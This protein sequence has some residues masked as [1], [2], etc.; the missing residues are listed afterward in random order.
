MNRYKRVY[1][2][3][4]LSDETGDKLLTRNI[5]TEE[6]MRQMLDSCAFP[7]EP[8]DSASPSQQGLVKI[9]SND[10]AI[11]NRNNPGLQSGNIHA[12]LIQQAPGT[13]V[14][15]GGYKESNPSAGV[16]PVPVIGNGIKVTGVIHNEG[17]IKR[18]GYQVEFDGG[19]LPEEVSTE[20]FFAIGHNPTTGKDFRYKFEQTKH[21]DSYFEHH[22]TKL[23]YT[24]EVNHGL[25]KYPAVTLLDE[26]KI[27][28]EA[29]IQ[30]TDKYN[31]IITIDPTS[32][33]TPIGWAIFN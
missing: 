11:D 20:D 16:F 23:E 26:S 9:Y 15:D 2:F 3:T 12:N 27:E 33:K 5:P 22:Q 28:F 13:G 31:V 21:S 30:H 8:Q 6:T 1:F 25:G 24:W 17:T 32:T 18:I 10:D 7:A 4:G 19:S 14:N 29:Q